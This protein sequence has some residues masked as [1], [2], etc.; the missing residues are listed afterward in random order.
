MAILNVKKLAPDVKDLIRATSGSSGLDIHAYIF[1][2]IELSITKPLLVPT[3]IAVSIH[4]GYEG[5]LRMRSG[6]A[7]KGWYMPNGVGTIDSDYTGEIKVALLATERGHKVFPG[8]RIAQLV[9]SKVSMIEPLY[10]DLL[11]ATLRAGGGF[12]STGL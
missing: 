10:V 2:E 6:L 1:D 7:S 11:D 9:I 5:Q 8:Q 3:G 4:R 12:G